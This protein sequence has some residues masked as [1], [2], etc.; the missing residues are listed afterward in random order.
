MTMSEKKDKKELDKRINLIADKIK[1]LRI[2]AGY[3]N[4]EE[5]AWEHSIGRMQYW[6]IEKGSNIT[7]TTL[8]KILDAHELSMSEFFNQITEK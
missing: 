8:F 4:Y 6:N 7:L 5:F 1:Q 2:D 3:S